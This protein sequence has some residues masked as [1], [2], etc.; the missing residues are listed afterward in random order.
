MQILARADCGIIE[1]GLHRQ[2]PAFWQWLGGYQLFAL[3]KHLGCGP[4]EH[5]PGRGGYSAAKLGMQAL[6]AGGMIDHRQGDKPIA[7]CDLA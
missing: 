2:P 3:G 6:L 1:V 4:F 5:T 7:H